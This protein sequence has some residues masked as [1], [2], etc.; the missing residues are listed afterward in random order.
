[1][2]PIQPNLPFL[3]HASKKLKID[4]APVWSIC[5]PRQMQWKENI[6]PT[7]KKDD[8]NPVN[9]LRLAVNQAFNIDT[10]TKDTEAIYGVMKLFL[11]TAAAQSSSNQKRLEASS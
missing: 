5:D 9:H 4:L 8:R 3:M 11:E 7:P 10:E 6:P 2:F 1:M